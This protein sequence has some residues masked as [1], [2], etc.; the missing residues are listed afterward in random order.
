M[1]I[2]KKKSIICRKNLPQETRKRAKKIPS[3]KPPK[4]KEEQ[5]PV[6]QKK[7]NRENK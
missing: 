4:I 6:S 7:T 2:F 1:P 3:N 5:K